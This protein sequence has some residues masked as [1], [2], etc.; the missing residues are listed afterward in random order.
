MA[1]SEC[2]GDSE[3]VIQRVRDREKVID[4]VRAT[5]ERCWRLSVLSA[6]CPFSPDVAEC[7]LPVITSASVI[8]LDN[9]VS[10][11]IAYKTLKTDC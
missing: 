5:Q 6:H 1:M 8:F 2:V 3:C 11:R 4:D 7:G 10:L 9:S